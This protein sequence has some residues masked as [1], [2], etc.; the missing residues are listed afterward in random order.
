MK[1]FK[2]NWYL[3]YTKVNQEKKVAG[4]LKELELQ[5]F[6]PLIKK[7]HNGTTQRKII[8]RPLFPSYLFVHLDSLSNYFAVLD[9]REV[10]NYV[11]FGKEYAIVSKSTINNIQILVNH[12]SEIRVTTDRFTTGKQFLID[13]GPLKG[14]ICEIVNR[15]KE[16]EILV[17]IEMLNRK[18]LIDLPIEYLQ[19]PFANC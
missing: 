17:S 9:L 2:P 13:D 12:D 11:R 6:L 1:N 5:T 15:T 7:V 19:K 18:L 3:I 16:T 10:V 8:H 14:L 4:Q